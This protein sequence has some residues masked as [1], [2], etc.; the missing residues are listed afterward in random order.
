M[1]NIKYFVF[2]NSITDSEFKKEHVLHPKVLQQLLSFLFWKRMTTLPGKASKYIC[3]A[4]PNVLQEVSLHML[5]FSSKCCRSVVNIYQLDPLLMHSV[6]H[7]DNKFCNP[8]RVPHAC[9]VV[10][11]SVAVSLRV[12]KILAK[13][14]VL[15]IKHIMD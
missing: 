1:F 11:F 14:D 12:Y 6:R 4:G 2:F 5:T 10:Y 13:F 7:N 15:N 8:C 3:E 9:I